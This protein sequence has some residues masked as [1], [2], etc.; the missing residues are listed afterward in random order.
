[1]VR[2]DSCVSEEQLV[3]LHHGDL[4]GDALGAVCEHLSACPDCDSRLAQVEGSDHIFPALRAARP[5]ESWAASADAY[6]RLEQR[7][8]V[9][10]RDAAGGAPP[11]TTDELPP[12]RVVPA[13]LGRYDLTEELGRGGMGIVFA[14]VHTVLNKR[15]AVKVI[16][17][18]YADNPRVVARFRR[19]V[20]VVGEM[21]HPN[22]VAATDA[23]EDAGCH[24]LVMEL[25]TG[26]DLATLLREAGPFPVADAAEAIRQA[27]VG[28]QYV[29]ERE[30]VHR[31]L[32]PSNLMLS[33]DGVV[34]VL[35]LGLAAL[36]ADGVP[37]GELTGTRLVMGTADYMAP[38]QWVD[39]HAVDIRA[40]I[41]S[42]GCTL[43]HVLTGEVP[44]P[45]AARRPT[46]GNPAAHAAVPTPSVRVIRP[47]VPPGLDAV[48]RRMLEPN[49]ADR[50]PTPQALADALA[51]F[52]TGAD[53][54]GLVSATRDCLLEHRAT[55][56]SGGRADGET[57]PYRG[58]TP[59]VTPRSGPRA[60]VPGRR[61]ATWRWAAAGGVGVATALALWVVFGGPKGDG[62]APSMSKANEPV[63]APPAVPTTLPEADNGPQTGQWYALLRNAPVPLILD[64]QP[65]N[66]HVQYNPKTLEFRVDTPLMNMYSFGSADRSDYKLQIG[67]RQTKWVGG[68]G[69]FFGHHPE[70]GTH[71]AG[72]K[73]QLLKL[74][75]SWKPGPPEFKMTR[76]WGSI[77]PDQQGRPGFV[78]NVS[79]ATCRFPPPLDSQEHVLGIEVRNGK[80]RNVTWN[81]I[82][83][84]DLVTHECNAAV[85]PADYVGAFGVV[86]VQSSSVFGNA[87][88][89]VL[90]GTPK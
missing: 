65:F 51:P 61:R 59:T 89:M 79:S 4:E 25:V 32:K 85:T 49:P 71:A 48:V 22:V 12:R 44:F 43:Y 36:F 38:E 41:Y 23:D 34:K 33:T 80:L 9:M 73:C 6:D 3:A 46:P 87:R 77:E 82:L 2:T 47:D 63:A 11:T 14:A 24:F 26:L 45:P 56:Q 54:K 35:D 69:I 86:V 84:P 88:L 58:R 74:E 28:L 31:D 60:A 70:P 29:H 19:E 72:A 40:D 42:L 90:E 27:A 75:P 64:N 57:A 81:G 21:A 78:R 1:V 13:R 16:L 50:Y 39:S 83:L 55:G 10:P 18:E 53:C 17:P 30:R 67:I 66:R 68:V 76:E 37:T 52:A 62:P 5:G 7:L 15:F 8:G 20:R